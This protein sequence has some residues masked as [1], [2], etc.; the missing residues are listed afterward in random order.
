MQNK[1]NK[2]NYLALSI[3]WKP[4]P[5]EA[6]LNPIFKEISWKAPRLI[7]PSH[8]QRHNAKARTPVGGGIGGGERRAKYNLHE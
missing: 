6:P 3:I 5:P 4:P 2:N 7:H 8:S 1:D